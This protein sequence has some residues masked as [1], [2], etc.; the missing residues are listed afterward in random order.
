MAYP[1]VQS[2]TT[3]TFASDTTAHAVDMPSTVNAGELLLCF[4]TNDVGATITTPSGWTQLWSSSTAIEVRG[5]AYYKVADGS[6]G[7]TTVDF[8][9]SATETA[10]AEVWR[11]SGW[12]GTYV[13]GVNIGTVVIVDPVASSFNPPAVTASWGTEDAL[14]IT[15]LQQSTSSTVT[16]YPTNYTDG[17]DTSSGS[18]ATFAQVRTARRNNRVTTEDPGS[19][20]TNITAYG[21]VNTVAIRPAT[22]IQTLDVP[23]IDSSL[24]F[25]SPSISLQG[26]LVPEILT[27]TPTFYNTSLAYGQYLLPE[28]LIV[29]PV[30][31]GPTI[32]TTITAPLLTNTPTFYGAELI[33]T[34][35]LAP[36]LFTNSPTFYGPEFRGPQ[37]IG[38]PLLTNSS[39]FYGP[40]IFTVW[41]NTDSLTSDTWTDVDFPFYEI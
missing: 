13:T 30:F 34:Q 8:V 1:T 17:T 39:T 26:V 22:N 31:Y 36:A 38:M 25:Y 6:E 14:W 15:T 7:G 21:I 37:N 20:T 33:N 41:T 28:I 29:E 32:N 27:I 18:G 4:F 35:V 11:I 12:W 19:Y 23:L 10:A 40:E 3:T 16:A 5:S 24:T 2:V 9:T